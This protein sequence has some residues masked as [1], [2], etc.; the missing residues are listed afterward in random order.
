[1]HFSFCFL[2]V[3]KSVMTD[4]I[5]RAAALCLAFL[6]VRGLGA[7]EYQGTPV[8]PSHTYCKGERQRP[9]WLFDPPVPAPVHIL[10]WSQKPS[11]KAVFELWENC[12]DLCLVQC[13]RM[14]DIPST[15]ELYGQDDGKLRSLPMDD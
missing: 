10:T 8:G 3:K 15:E 9:G 5:S 11:T 2:L 7:G 12:A 14:G 13:H 6:Q 4:T 1:M